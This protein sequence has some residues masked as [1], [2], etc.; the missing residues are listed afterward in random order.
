MSRKI[1]YNLNF[2]HK[3][4]KSVLAGESKRVIC[5]E[6]KIDTGLLKDWERYQK[7]WY[8]WFKT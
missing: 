3:A 6:L 8:R 4:V 5:I 7:I 1:K 2:K